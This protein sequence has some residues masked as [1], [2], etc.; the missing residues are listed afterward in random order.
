MKGNKLLFIGVLAAGAF[1][2][3]GCTAKEAKLTCTQT[4][5]GVDVEFIVGFKGN[6]IDSMDFSYDMSLEEYSDLQIEA[7]GEQDFC[8]VVKQSMTD[9]KEAFTS[10][11]QEIAE[12]HLKVKSSLDVDKIAK[13]VMGKMTT[14]E[15]GKEALESTGYKCVIEK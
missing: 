1:L 13:N 15:K 2:F 12:K 3:T 11:N 9:Y 4:N 5:N 10:C 14:P 6:V 7:I 8:S